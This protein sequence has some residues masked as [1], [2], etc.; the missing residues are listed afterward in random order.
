MGGRGGGAA[1]DEERVGEGRVMVERRV[2]V[3]L[4]RSEGD[5]VSSLDILS[6]FLNNGSCSVRLLLT[7]REKER[8]HFVRC[9]SHR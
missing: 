3:G 1:G 8:Q 2:R 7:C 5:E 9:S 6:K 4:C